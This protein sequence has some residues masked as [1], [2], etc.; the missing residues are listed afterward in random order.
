MGFH[1]GGRD[2]TR[3]GHFREWSQGELRLYVF[4][5]GVMLT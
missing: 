2:V 5:G 3:A 4:L 1:K